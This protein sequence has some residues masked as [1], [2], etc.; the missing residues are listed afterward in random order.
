M[1]YCT[2]YPKKNYKSKNIKM[3]MIKWRY[4]TAVS[5]ILSIIP[6]QNV[7]TETDYSYIQSF[8]RL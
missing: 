8:Q 2:L 5:V 1:Q 7:Y 3:C 4:E 6:G